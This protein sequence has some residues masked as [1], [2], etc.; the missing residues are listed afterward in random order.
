[1][2]ILLVLGLCLGSFVNAFVW[3]LHEKKDWVKG[4]SECPT[5]QHKLAAK[6]LVPVLSWLAL[7][8]R[9][10]YCHKPISWQY[11][12]VELLT[13]GLFVFSYYFWPL[14]LSGV[15][16]FEFILWLVFVVGFMALAVYDLRWRI[17]PNKVVYPLLVLAIAQ[18]LVVSL[19][20]KELATAW[21]ALWGVVV[22]AGF[23]YGLFQVSKGRWIGGG[24]VKLGALLGL[25][26]GGPLNSLLLLLIASLSGTLYTVPLM[27][28][29]KAK[30]NSQIPF[31]PFLILAAIIVQLFGGAIIAWY[32]RLYY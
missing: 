29:G 24:D 17:L 14:A 32:K 10:R 28:T 27:L 22:L 31:G 23:F 8:G 19:W 26:V 6:D 4:R 2:I 18:T 13:A 15:G 20:R 25:L 7:G 1:M 30:R 21:G 12:V 9:C 16:L 11:P 5:C 3:R